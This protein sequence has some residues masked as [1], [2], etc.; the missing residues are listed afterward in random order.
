VLIWVVPDVF[1]PVKSPV[2]KSP[3]TISA[4]VD[5]MKLEKINKTNVTD[6]NH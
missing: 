2:S 4:N 1:H 6:K 3:L 5:G